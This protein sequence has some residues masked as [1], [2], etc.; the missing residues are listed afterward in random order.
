MIKKEVHPVVI[1]K[2]KVFDNGDFSDEVEQFI[3]LHGMN[4]Y[5]A[6]VWPQPVPANHVV[7]VFDH[8]DHGI[9][10]NLKFA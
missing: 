7:I 2:D 5:Q 1:D 4:P 10:F 8:A 3:Q 9:F 6:T